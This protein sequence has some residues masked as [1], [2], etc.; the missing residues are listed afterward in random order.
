MRSC[1]SIFSL[2]A[3]S[4][5]AFG[6]HNDLTRIPGYISAL[7]L[8]PWSSFVEFDDFFVY[9]ENDGI[10]TGI[11]PIAWD[12][13][14]CVTHEECA[15]RCDSVAGCTGFEVSLLFEYCAIWLDG[16]CSGETDATFTDI[17]QALGGEA[18]YFRRS[19]YTGDLVEAHAFDDPHLALAE[20]GNADFRGE[21]NAIYNLLSAKNLSLNTR[22]QDA[23]FSLPG[24]RHKLVHGSFMREGYVTVRTGISGRLLHFEFTAARPLSATLEFADGRNASRSID[25][26]VPFHF[27]NVMAEMRGRTFCVTTDRWEACLTSKVYPGLQE[28]TCASGRC[29]LNV[30]LNALPSY[31]VAA[32]LVAPHGIIGQSFD[33]DGVP[34]SGAVDDY[35]KDE[36]TTSAQAEGA[37]EGKGSEY[38][39]SSKFSVDY[40]FSRFSAAAAPT[41]NASMLQPKRSVAPPISDSRAA[42][43]SRAASV[44]S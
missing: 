27:E 14:T 32:D 12:P 5:T 33:G 19:A 36:V 20:G 31:D 34:A 8:C 3:L 18:T 13:T 23:N 10:F 41:R 24:P 40:V 7:G 42:P 9:S 16:A 6:I 1:E 38:K 25:A 44:A 21:D 17:P 11:C 2:L 43:L 37:I 26:G 29:I 15:R 28:T 30:Q 35:S 39:M 22:F 4:R